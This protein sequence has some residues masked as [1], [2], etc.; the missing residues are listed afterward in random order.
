MILRLYRHP[1]TTIP[2]LRLYARGICNAA[3]NSVS[4]TYEM[5]DC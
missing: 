1:Y 5:S 4:R 2:P 3:A